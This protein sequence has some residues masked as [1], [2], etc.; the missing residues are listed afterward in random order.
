[1]ASVCVWLAQYAHENDAVIAATLQRLLRCAFPALFEDTNAAHPGCDAWTLVVH[2]LEQFYEMVLG[3][4]K[5]RLP[6]E[7]SIGD[8]VESNAA[9]IQVIEFT[10]GAVVQCEEK[11]AFVR[12]IM[13]MSDAV[14]VDLMAIIEKVMVLQSNQGESGTTESSATDNN[15]SKSPS[16]SGDDASGLRHPVSSQ[17]MSP[18]AG[19]NETTPLHLARNAELER[20]KRENEFLKDE[21]LHVSR[22]LQDARNK[23]QQM[24]TESSALVETIQQ[25]RLQLEVDVLKK[26]RAVRTHYEDRIQVLERDLESANAD[27]H[28]KAVVANEVKELRD[29]VDLLRPIAE[30]MT[31]MEAT[32]AKYKLKMEELASVKEKLRVCF[33]SVRSSEEYTGLISLET[34]LSKAASLQRKLD[35]AKEANTAVEF[36]VSELETLLTRQEHELE[37]VRNDWE[38][39]QSALHKA[40]ALNAQLQEMLD[41]QLRAANLDSGSAVSTE[42]VVGC[43]SEFNPELMQKLARLEH[44]NQELRKQVNGETSERIDG[45]LDQMDDLTRLKKSFESRYFDTEQQLQKTCE[46]LTHA[47]QA[48]AALE[49]SLSALQSDMKAATENHDILKAELEEARTV[50]NDLTACKEKLETNVSDGIQRESAMAETNHN[51]QDEV[52]KLRIT[53]DSLQ[54]DLVSLQEREA[55]LELAH[56]NALSCLGEEMDAKMT[57]IE[58]LKSEKDTVRLEMDNYMEQHTVSNAERN[59]KESELQDAISQLEVSLREE[60]NRPSAEISALNEQMKELERSKTLLQTQFK[61]QETK[62]TETIK[63]QLDSNHRLMESN[64]VLKSELQRKNTII[65]KLEDTMTRLESKVVLLEKERAHISSQEEKKREVEEEE[66]SFSSQLNT[67]VGLVVAELEKLQKEYKELR[68]RVE[69]CQCQHGGSQEHTDDGKKFYLNRIRQLE[70]GKHQEEDRRRELLLVNA[71]LI[72]EQKKF[73]TKN[74][75]LLTEL[76]Q[77]REK[78][79]AWLLRDERRKKEQETMRRKVQVL[80]SKYQSGSTQS[81]QQSDHNREQSIS[82]SK[83]HEPTTKEAYQPEGNLQTHNH[84]PHD[85]LVEG[86][87]DVRSVCISSHADESSKNS[88]DEVSLD[89]LPAQP[90]QHSKRKLSDTAVDQNPRSTDAGDGFADGSAVIGSGEDV[91]PAAPQARPGKRRMSLFMANRLNTQPRKPAE[92]DKPSECQQQ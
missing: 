19:S 21:N 64:Q 54:Q 83:Q 52:G 32:V 47:N 25:L 28:M 40:T 81:E 79:N 4:D 67:Q 66:M 90:S 23:I 89:I 82:C 65:A 58:Q 84:Q 86:T 35:E 77:L 34:Q 5:T 59:A 62:L 74:M 12:D 39:S 16:G 22:E 42:A 51:L 26:E 8:A 2:V 41:H 36:R 3:I 87:A 14:Q 45:L 33:T 6:L 92:E 60:Q 55:E 70:Q 73:Q 49:S 11:A 88:R 72:Q 48:V 1:M 61:N 24:E 44:E 63:A 71:K 78:M 18:L 37:R 80:E 29:E 20:A 91:L 68:E 75:M 7:A 15:T 69:S 38:S 85:R 56:S 31:K 17:G 57:E 27:L 10:L 13:T 76:Q 53:A 9:V 43:I 46:E 50:M 30:K